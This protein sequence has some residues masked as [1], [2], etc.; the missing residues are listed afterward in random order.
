MIGQF[1]DRMFLT[2]PSLYGTEKRRLHAYS[3]PDVAFY[4]VMTRQDDKMFSAFVN[5]IVLSTFFAVSEGIDEEDSYKMPLMSSFGNDML[6]ALRDATSANGNYD[7]IYLK[8][9]NVSDDSR[10]RNALNSKKGPQLLDM[11]GLHYEGFDSGT[12]L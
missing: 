8:N 4:P 11:P 7:Q 10:G 5:C 12:F 1:L 9:F 2:I 3:S 6:W